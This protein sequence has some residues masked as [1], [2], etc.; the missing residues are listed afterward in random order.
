MKI[1]VV[2]QTRSGVSY[3][4]TWGQW[5]FRGAGGRYQVK[6][7]GQVQ[8][9]L[10]RYHDWDRFQRYKRYLSQYLSQVPG[11]DTKIRMVLFKS[12]SHK[13]IQKKFGL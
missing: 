1:R 5:P 11:K 9:T 3:L 6:Y 2:T 13:L 10:K 8:C 12:I 7:L 4:P